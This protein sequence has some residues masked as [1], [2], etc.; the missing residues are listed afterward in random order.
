MPIKK[1]KS[2]RQ[3]SFERKSKNKK[4]SFIRGLKYE[5]MIRRKNK[6]NLILNNKQKIK[7]E[8]S[9]ISSSDNFNDK[10]NNKKKSK[11]KTEIIKKSFSNKNENILDDFVN[12]YRKQINSKFNSQLEQV[13]KFF[14][15]LGFSYDYLEQEE[16]P[17]YLFSKLTSVENC[18]ER[19]ELIE[20]IEMIVNNI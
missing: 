15:S 4:V 5:N 14:D 9:V 13:V 1:I 8:N 7:E 20:K 18:F 3:V 10:I 16:N 6:S 19:N 12:G 17:I 2:A 11:S